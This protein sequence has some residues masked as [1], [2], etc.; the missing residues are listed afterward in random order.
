MLSSSEGIVIALLVVLAPTSDHEPSSGAATAAVH[1]QT[2]MEVSPCRR[3]SDRTMRQNCAA[4]LVRAGRANSMSDI[5]FPAQ[6]N[7]IVP[8]DSGTPDRFRFVPII[9]YGPERR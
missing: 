9:S 8:I 2:D 1:E 4:R 6:V 3:F 5:R 7:W